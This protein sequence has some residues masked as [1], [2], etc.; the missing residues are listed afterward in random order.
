LRTL[1]TP[2]AQPRR[3]RA[4]EGGLLEGERSASFPR[5]RERNLTEQRSRPL[6]DEVPS[7]DDP[8]REGEP[9]SLAFCLG[10]GDQLDG[11]LRL[12][13]G[14]QNSS[15]IDQVFHQLRGVAEITVD[16]IGVAER[17]KRDPMPSLVAGEDG[18]RGKRSP[19]QVRIACLACARQELFVVRPCT[20]GSVQLEGAQGEVAQGLES[21]MLVAHLAK[22]RNALL[23][24][25]QRGLEVAVERVRRR[26][27]ELRVGDSP[28]I[29]ELAVQGEGLLVPS[30]PVGAACLRH[31][32]RQVPRS[33]QRLRACECGPLVEFEETFEALPTFHGMAPQAPELPDRSAQAQGLIC[34]A[35]RLQPVERRPQVLVLPL[36]PVEPPTRI[37]AEDAWLG[38]LGEG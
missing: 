27:L 9:E 25:R 14:D 7:C 24:E 2:P 12:A 4:S 23:D 15:E 8:R 26:E 10:P 5:L 36:E 17:A 6:L 16:A 21:T 18:E 20:L 3:S 33:G 29:A 31:L 22:P 11:E 13:G 1:Q 19:L 30:P 35:G 28:W 32:R 37:D 34:P 38:F